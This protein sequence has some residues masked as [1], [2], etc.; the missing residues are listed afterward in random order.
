VVI[1]EYL[2]TPSGK[3]VANP[4]KVCLPHASGDVHELLTDTRI[5]V[6]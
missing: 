5:S 1:T 2:P 3:S 6:P 4:Q